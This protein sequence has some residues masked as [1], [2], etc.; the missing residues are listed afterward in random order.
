MIPRNNF[1]QT[2][3]DTIFRGIINSYG[4]FQTYYEETLLPDLSSAQ[5]SWIG[6]VQSF[7]IMFSSIVS[8]PLLDAGYLNTLLRTGTCLIFLGHILLSLSSTYW[9]IFLTQTI[10][11]GL[12]S[13]AVFIP[14]LATLP[15]YFDTRISLA[16]GI[17]AS[18]SSLGGVI[19][20]I[21]L[22]R[23]IRSVGFPWA[24]R[25]LGFIA[26]TGLIVACIVMRVRV[27]VTTRRKKV[28]L[29]AFRELPFVTFTTGVFISFLGLYVPFYYI[30][31]FA[32]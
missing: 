18:G 6:S 20:P 7:I 16:M 17:A 26:L 23:L 24:V 31:P 1:P 22:H 8:G 15:T 14:G 3:T 5:I 25:V 19:Y 28:D 2:L 27:Q 32:M 12:G 13:G 29:T 21:S 11:I 4:V 10:C 30:Q 9:Q